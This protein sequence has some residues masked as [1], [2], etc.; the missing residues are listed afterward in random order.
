MRTATISLFSTPPNFQELVTSIAFDGYMGIQMYTHGLASPFLEGYNFLMATVSTLA[1]SLVHSLL[2]LWDP[3]AQADFTHQ[4]QLGGLWTFVALH[5]SFRLIG[6]S[7]W[8][9]TPS[10]VVTAIF[11]FILFFQ[12]FHN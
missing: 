1:N 12:G 5:G 6:Q 2:L 4:C 8:F 7:G 11:R 10:F 3:E 9:F